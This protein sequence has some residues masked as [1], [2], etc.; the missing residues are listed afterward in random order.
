MLVSTLAMGQISRISGT[1]SDDVDVL[2]GASVVEIDASNRILNS[3]VTDMNGNFVLAIK[4]PKNSLRISFMGFKTQKLPINKTVYKIKMEDATKTMKEVKIVAK[5]TMKTSGLAI[6]EREVSFSAQGISAKEFEGLGI[7]SVD[8]ALQGRIAGLD[9][10]QSGDLG[11]ASSMRLRGASTISQLGNEPLIVVNGNVWNVDQTDFDVSTANEERFAQLLNV[12]T[13]DIADIKV[14]KDAAATAI[15]GS[16]GA[17]G[18]IEITTKRG[19]RGPARVTYS[20]KLTFTHQPTGLKLLNG[21]QYT[22]LLK[23]S[24]FNPKQDPTAA[25]V[26]EL[27]YDENFSEYNMYN[28]NTDWVNLV[29]KT[30][31]RQNHYVSPST[32]FVPTTTANCHQPLPA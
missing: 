19:S 3:T 4:S 27:N 22:M 15:W 7:T 24:Y 16:Q 18:V 5:K 12:N 30:G 32:T 6:P 17:N 2:P 26:N 29:R 14:L 21:D 25:N 11:K 31:L 13:E 9:I 10:V 1:V 8:E 23:E 28:K 20:G